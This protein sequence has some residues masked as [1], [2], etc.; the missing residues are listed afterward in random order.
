MA[1]VEGG[2]GGGIITFFAVEKQSDGLGAGDDG[3]ETFGLEN[4]G[5]SGHAEVEAAGEFVAEANGGGAFGADRFEE[6]DGGAVF[7]VAHDAVVLGV[8]AGGEGGAVDFGGGGVDGVVVGEEGAALGESVEGGGVGGVDGVGPEAVEDD[9]D[10][11]RGSGGGAG[12][13]RDGECNSG[14]E[15]ERDAASHADLEVCERCPRCLRATGIGCREIIKIKIGGAGSMG[16]GG[17]VAGLTK[18]LR[19]RREPH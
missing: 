18:L 17:A 10:D 5:K 19:K 11:V 1:G 9:D 12:E 6:F 16:F 2:R 3:A 13:R 7:H 8:G 15:D 4:F 14:S